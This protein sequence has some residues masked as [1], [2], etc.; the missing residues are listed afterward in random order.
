MKQESLLENKIIIVKKLTKDNQNYLAE[1]KIFSKNNF[2]ILSLRLSEISRNDS[3][4]TKIYTPFKE[5]MR[6]VSG[7]FYED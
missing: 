7:G 6:I 5:L 4:S 2:R 1:I 3:A